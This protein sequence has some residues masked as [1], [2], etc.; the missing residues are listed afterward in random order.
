MRS[1]WIIIVLGLVLVGCQPAPAEPEE[2]PDPLTLLNTAAE[3]IRAVET[4]RLAV[5]VSGDAH[6]FFAELGNEGVVS[7][8]FIQAR[9]Q[10]AA[11]DIFQ[12]QVRIRYGV[13]IDVEVYA[14]A[15]DQFYRLGNLPWIQGDFAPEFTPA[16]LLAEETGFQAAL[17]TMEDLTYVGRTNLEDGQPVYHLTGRANGPQVSSLVVGL[18]NTQE[19]LP[20]DVFV[21]TETGYP[22]RITM[23]VP[24]ADDGES[25]FLIDVY[26]IDAPSE[27]SAPTVG[28]E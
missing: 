3:R 6:F 14:E 22:S 15:E 7:A 4:F 16:M 10:Y 26:D 28:E 12:G 23:R 19:D 21:H 9:A 25:V 13:P 24:Q 8:E 18:I 11:P 20:L 17:T 27:V 5:D 2:A 1:L